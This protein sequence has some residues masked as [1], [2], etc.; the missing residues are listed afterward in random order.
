MR[1]AY[2]TPSLMKCGPNVVLYNVIFNQSPAALSQSRIYYFSDSEDDFFKDIGIQKIKVSSLR[3]L[4]KELIRCDIVHSNGLRPDIAC[5]LLKIRLWFSGKKIKTITTIHNYV[6]KDL[7]YSYGLLSSIIFGSIWCLSW[8]FFNKAVVLS[9]HAKKYYW[10]LPE[11][12]KTTIP[13]GVTVN[14]KE[15]PNSSLRLSLGVPSSAILIGSCANLTARKGLDIVIKGLKSASNV[16][17]VIA[18]EGKE[19]ASLLKLVQSY[20]L[21]DKVHFIPY[22]SE[23]LKFIAQLDIFMMPSRSEGFGLTIIE[24]AQLNVPVI[25]SDIPIFK[26]LFRDMVIMFDLNKAESLYDEIVYVYN[27]KETLSMQA[28]KIAL[29]KYNSETM[30]A[31]YLALYK[32]VNNGE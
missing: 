15:N 20:D 3:L 4:A 8:L 16:H 18:G 28:K 29:E 13:N 23:P 10:F 11:K 2:I 25:T 17:F 21:M 24:A 31:S 9:E 5:T 7:F 22:V 32:V 19:K 30:T 6:F 1:I 27:N 12:Y 14:Y 26:E